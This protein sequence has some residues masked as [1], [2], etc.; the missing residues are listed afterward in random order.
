M[1]HISRVITAS[2][3]R[4]KNRSRQKP[5]AS[6]VELWQ[7]AVRQTHMPESE[8]FAKCACQHCGGHIEFPV[9][10]VGRRISCPHC[11]EPTL[12][13]RVAPVEIG[14]GRVA[15]KRIYLSLAI[16]VCLL[17]TVAGAYFYVNSRNSPQEVVIPANPVQPFDASPVASA[18]L[19]PP[20]PKPQPDLWHGLKASKV[21]LDKPGNG[22]LIYAIGA[23]TNETTRQ[24]F[25]V[26][27]E[28][29][30]LDAHR[31]KLGSATD[32]KEVI[33][34]G[35]VW[36]FRAMVTDKNAKTAKLTSVKEQE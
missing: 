16:A 6:Q 33:E 29:D 31:Y 5:I 22:S 24:R 9:Q 27:V 17:A 26:K 20:K 14:G 21:S 30:V 28:L 34:P 23:L 35:K 2:L 13:T 10:G 11:G 4:V 32:Y 1:I 7:C 8:N 25:G 15:R 3:A 12:L 36:N 18:P 19:P